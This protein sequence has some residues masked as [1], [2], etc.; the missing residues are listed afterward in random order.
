MMWLGGLFL[1]FVV[2]AIAISV[3]RQSTSRPKKSRKSKKREGPRLEGLGDRIM[4]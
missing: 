2:V 4:P 3:P 1:I